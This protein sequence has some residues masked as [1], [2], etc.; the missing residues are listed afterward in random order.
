MQRISV[1]FSMDW[2]GMELVPLTFHHSLR[3][4]NRNAG[5]GKKF[6]LLLLI[7]RVRAADRFFPVSTLV[8]K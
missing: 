8:E 5:F 2:E 1:H 7:Q 6:C 4:T 3:D